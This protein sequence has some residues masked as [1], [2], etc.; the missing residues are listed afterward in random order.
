MIFSLILD[1]RFVHFQHLLD[2]HSHGYRYNLLLLMISYL[3]PCLQQMR[4]MLLDYIAAA[5]NAAKII[6]ESSCG[7]SIHLHEIMDIYGDAT[8]F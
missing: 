1:P 4:E 2:L 8:T 5:E 6:P 7:E 3:K